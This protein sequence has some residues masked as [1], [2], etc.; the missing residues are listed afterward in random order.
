MT[1]DALFTMRQA[2]QRKGVS[3][4]TVS[5]AVRS[6]KLPSRRLGRMVLVT[7][8]DLD[9]WRPMRERRPRRYRQRVPDPTIGATSLDQDVLCRAE[10]EREVA[11]LTKRVLRTMGA[12]SAE[13]LD[14]L[15]QALARAVREGAS[16]IEK[17]RARE[18][19]CASY[20]GHPRPDS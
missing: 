4:H 18:S 6:G 11:T 10:L 14:V 8:A 3:Y 19:R 2:A 9:A 16:A 17:G 15:Q 12:L 1:D 5:R 20:L 7:A 13:Q